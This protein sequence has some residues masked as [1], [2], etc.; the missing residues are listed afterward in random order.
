MKAALLAFL[1]ALVPVA[2]ARKQATTP[3]AETAR[4]Y[5]TTP[6]EL[7]TIRDKAAKGTEPYRSAVRQVLADAIQPLPSSPTGQVTCPGA[8]DPEF[9]HRGAVLVY[10]KAIAYH[11]TGDAAYARG[12]REGIET[13]MKISGFG[14]MGNTSGDD[15]QCQL[16]V[17]WKIPGFVRAADLLED[18]PGWRAAGT[19]RR[20]QEWLANVVY[21]LVSYTA[22][23]SVSNWGAAA[24]NTEAHIADFLWDRPD[25]AL[26][27]HNPPGSATPTISRKTGDAY[28]HAIELALA[29]MN[30]ERAEAESGSSKSCD[31]E[32]F[33]KSMIR[34]DGGIPD[35]LRR[36]TTGCEGRR[37]AENDRSNMYSQT[38]L[39]NLIA[40]AELM[41]RRGDRRLYDNIQTTTSM[42][43]F[44]DARGRQQMKPLP[45][46]RGSLKQA[47]LFVLQTSNQP[48]RA[49]RSAGE[50]AYRY[51]RHPAMLRAVEATRP[52]SGD[53]AMS[54]ETLTHGFAANE[55]PANPPVTEPP[56]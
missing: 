34:P 54:Y 48:P 1:L 21:P 9:L 25:L 53:R 3:R 24:T 46:G 12:A 16:N 45:A 33:G 37:I 47:I 44:T 13:L 2:D 38:H 14:R 32:P 56:K 11:L 7:R 17:S 39:Q 43:K 55:N 41:L 52:N 40:Q 30:G 26:V 5:L 31:A 10:A 23:V 22:E 50:V 6:A 4:G 28:R 27:T 8:D 49:L 15:R 20:F 29:R 35:E 42:A 18:E 36:G 51:Y 19:K